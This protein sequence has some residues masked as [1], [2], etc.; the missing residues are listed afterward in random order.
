MTLGVLTDKVYQLMEEEVKFRYLKINK[1]YK[2]VSTKE[3]AKKVV[4]ETL[5]QTEDF[6]KQFPE[7]V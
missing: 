3:E 7:I 1:M 2:R 5:L 6:I 4:I